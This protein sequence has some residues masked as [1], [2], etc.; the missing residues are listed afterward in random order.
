MPDRPARTHVFIIDGTLSSLDDGDETNAGLLYKLLSETGPI[1]RQT[2]GY[3]P[4]VQADGWMKWIHIA[5][6]SGINYSIMEGYAALASRYEPGD[7]IMI[8]GFSRGAYAA[9]SLAGFIGRIGLIRKERAT[10]RRIHRA[11]RYYESAKVSDPARAFTTKY[12]HPEAPIK[13]LGVWDTV[14]AL[15]LPYPIL[16]RLAPM[17]TE[18][19]DHMLSP[20]TQNAFQAL[21][22]DENRTSYAPLPWRIPPN[23]KAHVEQAWF[24][25]AHPDIGGHI[26]SSPT[27]RTLSNIPFVWMLEKAEACGLILPHGWRDEFPLNAAAKMHGP[28]RGS[29]KLFIARGP[30]TVGACDSEYIHASVRAR[31]DK[32]PKYKPRADVSRLQTESEKQSLGQVP[33]GPQEPAIS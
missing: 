32:L 9:R 26:M 15:G 14:K 30:R 27:S 29:A 3:N 11:F 2:V 31:Q 4:G 1:A 18:F 20:N 7:D 25:G 22:I 8:F 13:V 17:A 12:C 21:A 33:E 19:H 28:Y 5:A 10:E 16:N 24:P 6:G 23:S